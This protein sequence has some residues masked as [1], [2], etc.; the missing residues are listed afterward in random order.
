MADVGHFGSIIEEPCTALLANVI[1]HA[2]GIWVSIAHC[3]VAG[4]KAIWTYW[5]LAV[6]ASC[7]VVATLSQLLVPAAAKTDCGAFSPQ[8]L[9]HADTSSLAVCVL[10][11]R[12]TCEVPPPQIAGIERVSVCLL[13]NPQP[14]VWWVGA[15]IAKSTDTG[16]QAAILTSESKHQDGR[17][18][19]DKKYP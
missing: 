9:G 16:K 5:T 6:G 1:L 4:V 11:A 7:L 13:W 10:V 3:M 18:P 19:S 15:N 8:K 17:S 2:C 14:D 12:L